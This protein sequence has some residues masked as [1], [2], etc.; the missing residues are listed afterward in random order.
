MPWLSDLSPTLPKTETNRLQSHGI[1][2]IFVRLSC[3]LFPA[4]A[5]RNEKFTRQ[6]P[7]NVLPTLC[8]VLL[9]M[10]ITVTAEVVV[11]NFQNRHYLKMYSPLCPI[12]KPLPLSGGPKI[13]LFKFMTET[14][15]CVYVFLFVFGCLVGVVYF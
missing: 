10:P 9:N 11:Q 13:S 14:Q 1:A 8:Y 5:K 6:P 3:Q 7:N 4:V 2:I 12:L 15:E